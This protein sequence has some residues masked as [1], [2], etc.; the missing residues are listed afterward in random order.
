MGTQPPA[1]QA[2]GLLIHLRGI[3]SYPVHGL[4]FGGKTLNPA[5]VALVVSD[6]HVPARPQLIGEGFH[7]GCFV[8]FRHADNMHLGSSS[9]QGQPNRPAGLN[10]RTFARD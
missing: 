7:D 9:I 8:R 6:D 3:A 5:L 10:R 1:C 4:A 2:R